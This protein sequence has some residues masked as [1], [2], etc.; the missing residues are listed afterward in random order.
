[1]YNGVPGGWD[2]P[3][4]L[5]LD[6]AGNVYVTGESTQIQGTGVEDYATVKYDADGNEQWVRRYNGLARDDYWAVAV[7]VDGAG[8]VYV[9]GGS[10]G[11]GTD[12]DYAT[13]KYDADGHEQW[14]ARY[15]G[16]A[17]SAEVG[18]ALAVDG[19]GNVYVT[20]HSAG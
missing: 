4:D 14:V 11:E 13:V 1:M 18:S 7:V 3:R 9:T 2:T 5:A 19:C 8:N 16:P 10:L 20:G 15:N 6:Q 17:T 12:S